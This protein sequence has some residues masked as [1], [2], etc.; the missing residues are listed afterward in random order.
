MSHISEHVN[1]IPFTCVQDKLEVMIMVS[2]WMEEEE[3]D[4]RTFG[5]IPSE[6]N[7]SLK[8]R[9]DN[10]RAEVRSYSPFTLPFYSL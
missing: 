5:V 4:K 7:I 3:D 8:V 9:R 10:V 6:E 2:G 1:C